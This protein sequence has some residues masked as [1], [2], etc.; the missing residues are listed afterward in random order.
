M[1]LLCILTS[2]FFCQSLFAPN[3]LNQSNSFDDV[4]ERSQE[5]YQRLMTSFGVE[6]SDIAYPDDYGGAYINDDGVLVVMTTEPSIDQAAN[7]TNAL[8]EPYMIVTVEHSYHELT[9]LKENIDNTYEIFQTDKSI[10][11]E[12]EI[13]L[14]ESIDHFYISQKNNSVIVGIS[15]LSDEKIRCFNNL[16]GSSPAYTFIEGGHSVPT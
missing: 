3:M 13:S 4:Y 12:D 16:F 11:T 10:F 8:S 14:L 2:L 7:I 9:S 5:Q 15:D 6:D 1:K